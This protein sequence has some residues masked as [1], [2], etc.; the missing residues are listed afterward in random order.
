MWYLCVQIASSGVELSK[1]SQL[2]EAEA[3]EE[4]ME[5]QTSKALTS[6]AKKRKVE[7]AQRMEFEMQ[8]KTLNEW[9]TSTE[10]TLRLL[11]AD[12][13]QE[14][15]TVEEQ[16]VLIQVRV[17]GVFCTPTYSAYEKTVGNI[18]RHV[19]QFIC[20]PV[21]DMPSCGCF[22]LHLFSSPGYAQLWMFDGTRVSN[23]LS[24]L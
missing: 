2:Y 21:Q 5:S 23:D 20:F 9:F 16:R 11:V 8:L 14:P 4:R 17:R 18:S 1:I 12:N 22:T 3:G 10:S 19:L 15:F 24:L 6:A 13:S 7:S